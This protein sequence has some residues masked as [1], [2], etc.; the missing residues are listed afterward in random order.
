MKSQ[1]LHPG[2]SYP[3]QSA[4]AGPLRG[5]SQQV[6]FQLVTVPTK[7]RY[8]LDCISA[9]CRMDCQRQGSGGG[10]GKFKTVLKSVRVSLLLF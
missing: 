2:Q 5:N 4:L 8:G 1:F 3:R 9:A 10:E 6:I 7:Q